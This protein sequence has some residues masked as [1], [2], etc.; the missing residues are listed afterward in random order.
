MACGLEGGVGD[1]GGQLS[2]CCDGGRRR[3]RWSDVEVICS[4]P[5]NGGEGPTL[6]AGLR[7]SVFL[8]GSTRCPAGS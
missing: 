5:G 8:A 6:K 3:G 7:A 4:R 1:P 2:R